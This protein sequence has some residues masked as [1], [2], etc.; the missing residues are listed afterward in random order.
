MI[1]FKGELKKK[2]D[3]LFNHGIVEI[4][5]PDGVFLG[6][7]EFENNVVSVEIHAEGI[8]HFFFVS[9]MCHGF[10]V[11]V[12]E[13]ATFPRF[14]GSRHVYPGVNLNFNFTE[15]RGL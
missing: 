9:V 14:F 13:I 11:Y 6:S 8:A 7:G 3:D 5:D 12:D 1:L 15:R 4:Y 2:I 10:E